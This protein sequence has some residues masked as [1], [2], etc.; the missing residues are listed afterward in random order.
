MVRGS[1]GVER[2][3]FSICEVRREAALYSEISH[4]YVYGCSSRVML[5]D[6][7]AFVSSL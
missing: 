7:G 5:L 1:A 4:L 6:F 2:G 3:S